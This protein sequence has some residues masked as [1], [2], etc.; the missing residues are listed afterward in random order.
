MR[1]RDILILLMFLLIINII[2]S[3]FILRGIADANMTDEVEPIPFENIT[4]MVQIAANQ[5]TRE[6]TKTEPGQTESVQVESVNLT[7]PLHYLGEFKA[8]AYCGC[9]K[10]NGKWAGLPASDGSELVDGVTVASDWDVLPAGTEIWIPGVGFRTCQDTGYGIDGY[11][12]DIYMDSHHAALNW[13]VKT[14]KVYV[15]K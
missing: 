9:K 14:V 8:T 12:L 3:S 5:P 4:M 7:P 6:H 1:N 10:C 11:D 15:V 13:G 2:L